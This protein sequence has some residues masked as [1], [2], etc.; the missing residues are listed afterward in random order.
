MITSAAF[1]MIDMIDHDYMKWLCFDGRRVKG[2]ITTVFACNF[3]PQIYCNL[4]LEKK[5]VVKLLLLLEPNS[6]YLQ[7]SSSPCCNDHNR[8]CYCSDQC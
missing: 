5:N 6:Y 1:D 3:N 2:K 4:L 7:L 8:V